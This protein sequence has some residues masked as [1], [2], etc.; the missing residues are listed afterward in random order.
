MMDTHSPRIVGTFADDAIEPSPDSSE[1]EQSVPRVARPA[2]RVQRVFTEADESYESVAR[3][4]SQNGAR[5]G[6]IRQLPLR[7]IPRPAP[8]Q[9][10]AGKKSESEAH[11][12]IRAGVP[13]AEQSPEPIS[14][15][16]LTKNIQ[17]L[18]QDLILGTAVV[19]LNVAELAAHIFSLVGLVVLIFPGQLI[20]TGL[21]ALYRRMRGHESNYGEAFAGSWNTY[22]RMLHKCWQVGPFELRLSFMVGFA[23][24]FP[25]V[26]LKFLELASALAHL[27]R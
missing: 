15:V 18:S 7:Q 4:A 21:A 8:V 23:L 2:L 19:T 5:R 9:A 13:V 16:E 25:F 11:L 1:A 26:A 22:R 17:K 3:P 20:H 24:L 27:A 12:G 10:P 14:T 6:N